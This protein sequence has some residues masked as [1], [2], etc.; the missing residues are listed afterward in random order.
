MSLPHNPL[1]AEVGAYQGS[2]TTI[3]GC[4]AKLKE[5]KVFT[6]DAWQYVP[7]NQN[8]Y[9]RDEE[10]SDASF[11]VW[12]KQM[13]RC[14]LT[15]T[16]TPIC[17]DSSIN[18]KFLLATRS[19]DLIYIDGGHELDQPQKD[20]A[21]FSQGV[22]LGGLFILHDAD[23]TEVETATFNTILSGTHGKWEPISL[24][25]REVRMDTYRLVGV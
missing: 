17:G 19:Y 20:V 18:G 11:D 10:D 1:I 15:D 14:S 12:Q 8:A 5:G 24:Y 25:N 4:A 23:R 2:S 22:K 9:G 13:K 16:V 21:I 6:F 7:D 3:L